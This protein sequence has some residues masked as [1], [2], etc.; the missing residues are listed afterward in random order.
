MNFQNLGMGAQ[1]VQSFVN[2]APKV[3]SLY[4]LLQFESFSYFS[5]NFQ[6]FDNMKPFFLKDV[7]AQMKAMIDENLDLVIGEN[8]IPDSISPIDNA[9][10]DVRR[11]L[12]AKGYVDGNAI[13]IYLTLFVEALILSKSPTTTHLALLAIEFSIFCFMGYRPFIASE[14]S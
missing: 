13:S 7:Y 4:C 6:T 2:A 14:I 10:A 5:F 8:Q 9:I 11:I 1:M 3:V 12:R